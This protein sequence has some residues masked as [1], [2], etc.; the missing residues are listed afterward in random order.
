MWG[1]QG[2]GTYAWWLR[3]A[4][5]CPAQWAGLST[6]TELAFIP[7]AT[8]APSHPRAVLSTSV[9]NRAVTF[10]LHLPP[11]MLL[12]TSH[13]PALPPPAPESKGFTPRR[14]QTQAVTRKARIPGA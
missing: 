13:S 12:T 1:E 6:G 4:Q 2:P 9:P 14:A 7:A 10:G 3:L 5:S 11:D 8:K